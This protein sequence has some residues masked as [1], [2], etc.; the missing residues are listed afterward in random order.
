MVPQTGAGQLGFNGGGDLTSIGFPNYS[1]RLSENNI[2]AGNDFF[3]GGKW[4]P[5]C[6]LLLLL[7]YNTYNRVSLMTL[8]TTTHYYWSLN[9]SSGGCVWQVG[10]W[11]T[12]GT[13]A[14]VQSAWNCKCGRRTSFLLLLLL[15]LLTAF[16]PSTPPL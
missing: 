12:S 15:L 10:L 5:S 13:S 8:S 11:R 7:H 3:N 6:L 16:S 14:C 4:W 9:L 2:N 1:A